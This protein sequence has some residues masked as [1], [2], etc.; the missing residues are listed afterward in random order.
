VTPDVLIKLGHRARAE[1]LL[2]STCGNAS[3]RADTD[4]ILIS[5]SGTELGLL[6]RC[7]VALI[8]I[9]DG[10]ASGG[11]RPSSEHPLHRYIYQ[12]RPELEVILHCQSR[13]ATV[14]ACMENPPENLDLIPEIPAYVKAFRYVAYAPP[15]SDSLARE[16][17]QAF[18]DPAVGI[19]QMQNHGQVVA[20][21]SA[22]AAIQKALFFELA[23]WMHLQNP[24]LRRIPEAEAARLRAMKTV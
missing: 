2:L 19:V 7:D 1:G 15:G 24:E 12:R 8:N 4:R 23:A 18:S 22:E 17:A 9:A 20:A 3:V 14:L 13:A 5:A 21:R 10:S 11:I 16:V 6:E